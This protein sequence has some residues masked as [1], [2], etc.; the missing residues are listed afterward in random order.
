MNGCEKNAK[1]FWMKKLRTENNNEDRQ[2]LGNEVP[3]ERQESQTSDS[4][5]AYLFD[6]F[7]ECQCS[8]PLP[9]ILPTFLCF[10]FV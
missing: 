3:T 6:S 1:V 4:L 7:K 2:W 10:F 8:E 5:L 9:T